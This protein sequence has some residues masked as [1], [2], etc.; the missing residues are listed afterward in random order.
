MYDAEILENAAIAEDI[1]DLRLRC[2]AAAT[3]VAGQFVAVYT[4]NPATL[5]P[6]PLSICEVN[7]DTLRIIYRIAGQGT[8]E[9][10]QRQKGETLRIMAPLGN[11]FP[12]ENARGNIAIVGGGIGSPPLLQ[13]TKSIRQNTPDAKISVYLGFRSAEH[14]ILEQDF[15]K[16]ADEIFIATDDGS[17]GAAGNAVSLLEGSKFDIIYACGPHIML[18]NL[19]KWADNSGTICYVSLEER[20]A[21]SIGACLACVAKIRQGDGTTN[22]TVCAVGPVFDAKELVWE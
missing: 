3:A 1:Y 14:V 15:A 17:H 2:P 13:L 6:R 4:D 9:I 8:Q 20:M 19:A 10:S 18:K 7:D 22:K 12:L 21:C 5:L 11:G 16:Y